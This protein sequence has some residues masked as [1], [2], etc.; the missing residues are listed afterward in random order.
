MFLQNREQQPLSCP[1]P[2][3]SASFPSVPP[4]FPSMWAQIL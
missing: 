4:A 2:Q 3:A 1:L